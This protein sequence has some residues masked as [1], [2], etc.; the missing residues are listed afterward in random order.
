MGVVVH[1]AAVLIPSERP[2]A[3]QNRLS[4]ARQPQSKSK[5]KLPS[6]RIPKNIQ[7]ILTIDIPPQELLELANA[8]ALE[9][10]QRPN[11]E[12]DYYT[13]LLVLAGSGQTDHQRSLCMLE[14]MRCLRDMQKD[15]RMRAWSAPGVS[16]GTLHL[17]TTSSAVLRATAAC[18][19]RA[20]AKRIWFDADEFFGCVLLA[21][22]SIGR[23]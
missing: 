23:A 22:E 2:R 21:A 12:D 10:K 14:R 16:G 6:S 4:T 18:P 1:P 5:Q 15:D 9:K 17:L 7:A 3:A 11:G 20:D 8:V 13:A 19:L